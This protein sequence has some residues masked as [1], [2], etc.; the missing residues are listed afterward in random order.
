MQA[1]LNKDATLAAIV[2]TIQITAQNG[3]VTLSG[4]VPSEQEKQ[5]IEAAVKSAGNVVSVNNQLQVSSSSS[6]STTSSQSSAITPAPSQTQPLSPTSDR[7]GSQSR[8]YAPGQS[9]ATTP[10]APSSQA[11]S[12]IKNIKGMTE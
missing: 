2:P 5:K 4:K 10:P 12:F 3:T 1:E 6:T 11:D 9:A 8:V 7:Q